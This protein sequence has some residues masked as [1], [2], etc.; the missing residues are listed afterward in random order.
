MT[1]QPAG[2]LIDSSLRI[3]RVP[4]VTQ[5]AFPLSVLVNFVSLVSFPALLFALLRRRNHTSSVR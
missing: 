4:N 1:I 2:W 3:G 5:F